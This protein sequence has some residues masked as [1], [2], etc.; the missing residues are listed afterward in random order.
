MPPSQQEPSIDTGR[1]TA[2]LR[3]L[4]Q[5]PSGQKSVGPLLQAIVARNV[6]IHGRMLSDLGSRVQ[7]VEKSLGDDSEHVTRVR[8]RM[9]QIEDDTIIYRQIA[10]DNKQQNAASALDPEQ[11]KADLTET[12]NQHF[13][14]IAG[15]GH[16]LQTIQDTIE[17]QQQSCNQ[18]R[19]TLATLGNCIESVKR[20]MAELKNGLE[21]SPVTAPILDRIQNLDDKITEYFGQTWESI[22]TAK[23]SLPALAALPTPPSTQE[24][25]G[26]ATTDVANSVPTQ[27][28]ITTE[29]DRPMTDSTDPQEFEEWPAIADFVDVYEEFNATYKSRQPQDHIKFIQELLQEVGKVNIHVSCAL[30]RHLLEMYPKRV[31]LISP[32]DGTQYPQVF[33]EPGRMK[34][35]DVKRAVGNF[36]MRKFQWA[37]NDGIT[38]P[39]PNYVTQMSEVR[40]RE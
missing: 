30:Q 37:S 27:N 23:S 24:D 6:D 21:R 13:A 11:L 19:E 9:Q 35:S 25:I 17:G 38:G 39:K 5:H 33:I 4:L 7:Q 12:I 34:W 10:Q 29:Q 3:G 22:E 14:E 32:Q 20:D 15:V 40:H 26:G 8:E 31:K 16:R 18:T 36:D 28:E 1:K 2:V